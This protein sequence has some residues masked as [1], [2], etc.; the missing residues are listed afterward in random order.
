MCQ[1]LELK[2]EI[3]KNNSIAA[4]NEKNRDQEGEAI[5]ILW[6]KDKK[7]LIYYLDVT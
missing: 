3:E 4:A 2:I 5:F 1:S 6:C 7:S